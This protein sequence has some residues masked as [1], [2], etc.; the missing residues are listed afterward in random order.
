MRAPPPARRSAIPTSP[1]SLS[2]SAI[3]PAGPGF[4]TVYPDGSDRPDTSTMNYVA[5][6]NVTNDEIVPVG[7]DGKFAITVSGDATQ[8]LVDVTGYFTSNLHATSA[9]TYTPLANSSR[10]LLTTSCVGVAKG[11][12][13]ASSALAFH[14]ANNNGTTGAPVTPASGTTVTAVALNIGAG[15]KRRQRLDRRLRQR[16]HPEHPDPGH[17]EGPQTTADT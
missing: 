5:S 9:S 14:V 13:A 15:A 7:P 3:S 6:V 1:L 17:L 16:R 11:T 2:R 10:V 4:L 12:V 8:L